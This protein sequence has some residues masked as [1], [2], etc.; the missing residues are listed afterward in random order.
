MHGTPKA[1]VNA[2]AISCYCYFCCCCWFIDWH[3]HNLYIFK[4]NPSK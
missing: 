1:A 4:N 3:P 2:H